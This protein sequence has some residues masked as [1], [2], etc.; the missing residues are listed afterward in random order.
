M[1]RE[2]PPKDRERSTTSLSGSDGWLMQVSGKSRSDSGGLDH[3]LRSKS[4]C[5]KN[6]KGQKSTGNPPGDKSK[7]VG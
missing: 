6:P 1:D 4:C 3:L 7:E 5:P 2:S